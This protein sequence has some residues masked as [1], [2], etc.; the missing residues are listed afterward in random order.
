MKDIIDTD[1]PWYLDLENR[2][3]SEGFKVKTGTGKIGYTYHEKGLV[4]GKMPV[5]IEGMDLPMLCD[6]ATL[7]YIQAVKKVK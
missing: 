5:Y 3:D 6:P 7:M 2:K 4:N 1:I